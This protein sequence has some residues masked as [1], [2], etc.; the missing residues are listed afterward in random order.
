MKQLWFIG[1]FSQQM[2]EKG[3]T[4][5]FNFFAVLFVLNQKNERVP[6]IVTI[7]IF[8]MYSISFQTLF[9]QVF[10]IALDS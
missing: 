3:H 4:I 2:M 9:V 5:F 1:S 10:K 7:Y 8:V 6:F